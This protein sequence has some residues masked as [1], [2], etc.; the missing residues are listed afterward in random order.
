MTEE[1]SASA[2]SLGC[3]SR[4]GETR[5]VWHCDAH[6]VLLGVG[7]FRGELLLDFCRGQGRYLAG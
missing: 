2:M 4:F 3:A 5:V 1:Q 6:A 7:E